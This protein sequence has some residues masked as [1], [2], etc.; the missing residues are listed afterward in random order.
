MTLVLPV[1]FLMLLLAVLPVAVAIIVGRWAGDFE[2][3]S[4]SPFEQLCT[5]RE[6]SGWEYWTSDC[7][8]D[9]VWEDGPGSKHGAV[10]CSRCGKRVVE[11]PYVEPDDDDE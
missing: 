2:K 11:V 3:H 1:W 7:G 5:H 6:S 4:A 8:H 10:F 9:I